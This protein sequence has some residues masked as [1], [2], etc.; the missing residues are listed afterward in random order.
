MIKKIKLYMLGTFFSSM[1]V[2][3]LVSIIGLT[4]GRWA[5]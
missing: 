5:M 1:L 4:T 2:L 3:G